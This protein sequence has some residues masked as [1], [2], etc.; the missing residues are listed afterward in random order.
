MKKLNIKLLILSDEEMNCDTK[1][2]TL[3][4][5]GIENIGFSSLA[6]QGYDMIIYEG[7]KGSKILKSRYTKKGEIL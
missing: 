7:V 2:K 3:E 6:I 4:N 1:Q 5:M